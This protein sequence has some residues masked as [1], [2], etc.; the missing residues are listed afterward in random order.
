LTGGSF[1]AVCGSRL[2]ALERMDGQSGDRTEEA[3]PSLGMRG[4]DHRVSPKSSRMG[5]GR[6]CRNQ[7][8]YEIRR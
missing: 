1:Q 5:S 8:R 3:E 4:G 2:S 7:F 6:A